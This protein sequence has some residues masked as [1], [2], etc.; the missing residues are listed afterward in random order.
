MLL[1]DNEIVESVWQQVAAY[2]DEQASQGMDKLRDNQAELIE[3]VL[4]TLD[5]MGEEVLEVAVYVMYVV[6]SIF[7]QAS[8]GKL[9][10]V[11]NDEILSAHQSNQQL[12]L[13]PNPSARAFHEKYGTLE[14]TR[15][16]YVTRYV[17][18]ALVEE[19]AGEEPVELTQD[20]ISSAY[21][22]LRTVIDVLDMALDE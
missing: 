4:V 22:I 7:E 16:P 8:N 20:Q 17:I 19:D 15:Q 18:D 5:G 10:Q 9:K 14:Q 2:D 12:R 11:T 13:T 1:I 21:L 3:Y 6:C